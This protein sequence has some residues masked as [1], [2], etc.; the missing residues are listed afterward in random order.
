[1][2]FDIGLGEAAGWLGAALSVA[3]QSM[4][5]MIPLRVLA[6]AANVFG[7]LYGGL[8][9]A[10]PQLVSHSL[11]LPMNAL[12]L[13]QMIRLTRRAREAS[14]GDLN[15]DW[16]KPYM[17]RRAVRAGEV[18]FRR[19]EEADAVYLLAA[20]R[21]RLVESGIVPALGEMIGELGLLAPDGC[22]TQTLRAE[23]DGEV[24]AVGYGDL[25]QLL[26]QNPAFGFYF[27]RLATGRLF[28]NLAD[29]ERRAAELPAAP[30]KIADGS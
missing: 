20:G 5:T 27:M 17:T 3:M 2:P 29:A 23:T 4:R 10:M 18:L 12:R 6:I 13:H 9:G 14:R 8:T 22:R 15:M 16:L 1:M 25:R 21:F 7:I 19:G 26:L 24:L 28:Q 11:L 30:A